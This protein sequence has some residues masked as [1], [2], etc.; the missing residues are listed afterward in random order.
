MAKILKPYEVPLEGD[1]AKEVLNI[2]IE[3]TGEIQA[4]RTIGERVAAATKA[5]E[6]ANKFLAESPLAALLADTLMRRLKKRGVPSLRV[7]PDGTVILH[8]SYDGNVERAE[9][10]IPVER[11][12]RNMRLGLPK[13]EELRKMAEEMGVDISDLGTKRRHI[14]DRLQE[15]QNPKPPTRMIDEVRESDAPD[16]PHPK[17]RKRGPVIEELDLRDLLDRR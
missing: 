10:P 14:Y 4:A 11:P 1:L 17:G 9:Q 16:T 15:V 5:V 8:V 12:K 2:P 7:R 3:D 13:L 6:D